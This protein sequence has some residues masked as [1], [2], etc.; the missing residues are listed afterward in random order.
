DLKH[1]HA[2]IVFDS[3]LHLYGTTRSA[4]PEKFSASM[5]V[6]VVAR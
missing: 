2:R 6:A 4:P 3:K 5:L 1:M